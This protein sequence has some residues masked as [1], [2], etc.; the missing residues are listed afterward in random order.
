MSERIDKAKQIAIE[1]YEKQL[2]LMDLLA[3]LNDEEQK[4]FHPG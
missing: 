2:E 1:F 3:S 4:I